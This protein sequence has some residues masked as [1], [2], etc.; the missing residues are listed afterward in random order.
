MANNPQNDPIAKLTAMLEVVSTRL[1][2]LEKTTPSTTKNLE[3]LVQKTTDQYA[4]YESPDKDIQLPAKLPEKFS[5][6][7]LPKFKPTDNPRFHLKGFRATIIIKGVDL[8]LYPK[9]FPLS[10]DPVCQKWFFS[11]SDKDTATWEDITHAFMT[12]Y[13][14]NTQVS[15]SLRELE[16]LKQTE[17][18]GFTTYLARWKE[19]AAQMVNPPSEKEM[20]KIFVSNL[21]PKYRNHLWYLGLET[22]DKVYHIGIEIE[23]DLLKAN[24]NKN[25]GN[26]NKN[27]GK[28]GNSNYSNNKKNDTSN[29]SKGV[30]SVDVNVVETTRAPPWRPRREYTPLGMTY[31]QAFDRLKSK[32]ALSPIG[33]TAD[34]PTER[35]SPRWDPNKYCKYHQGKGHTTEECWTLKNKLQD[36]V[37]SGQL[38]VPPGGKKPNTDTS[39]L[40]VLMISAEEAPF[41]PV[42]YITPV[43]QELPLIPQ[44]PSHHHINNIG[45]EDEESALDDRLSRVLFAIA[46]G[47]ESLDARIEAL[48]KD[49]RE[50]KSLLLRTA[51]STHR[52]SKL[53]RSPTSGRQYTPLAVNR[54]QAYRKLLAEGLTAPMGPTPDPQRKPASWDPAKYCDYHQ[55]RGH[56]AEEC[57]KVNDLFQNLMDNG[58]FVEN[59]VLNGD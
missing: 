59:L 49:S 1:D 4:Y 5:A 36:M 40:T 3:K 11:Q 53:K 43:G 13:K 17:K 9:V 12:S 23:D 44:L 22:F 32:G 54:T 46:E 2:T 38:P 45:D 10:L 26:N 8:V 6:T 16:I 31:T 57:L 28:W 34:P 15:T 47:L 19:V 51:K 30:I 50:I 48:E 42:N 58:I 39:P 24:D 21:L 41:D 18:E 27:K 29:S 33:P 55:G 20:V 52:A 14:G 56:S 37:E 35:R 25:N 7:D